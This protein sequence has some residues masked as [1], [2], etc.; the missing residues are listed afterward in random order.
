MTIRSRLEQV[1]AGMPPGASVSLP[2]EAIKAWLM[3][4]GAGD[5]VDLRA[6]DVGRLFGRSPGTIRLW[7]R[8]G[9]LRAYRLGRQWRVPRAALRELENGWSDRP[10]S[11]ADLGAWRTHVGV[12]E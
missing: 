1:I 12:D 3:D 2:V 10:A 11:R 5:T 7:I 6:E 9:R 8:Q 4:D